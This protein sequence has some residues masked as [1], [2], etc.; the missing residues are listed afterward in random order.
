MA[1]VNGA[2]CESWPAPLMIRKSLRREVWSEYEVL[3]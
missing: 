3:A 2:K 1:E